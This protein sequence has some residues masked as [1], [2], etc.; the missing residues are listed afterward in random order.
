MAA[1]LA[2]PAHAAEAQSTVWFDGQWR[3]HALVPIRAHKPRELARN[4]MAMK[5]ADKERKNGETW[6]E[7]LQFAHQWLHEDDKVV[8]NLEVQT[9]HVGELSGMVE[10]LEW[11]WNDRELS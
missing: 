8:L 9:Q 4:L 11:S 7:A 6:M 3:L 1:V 5:M 10:Y 2:L